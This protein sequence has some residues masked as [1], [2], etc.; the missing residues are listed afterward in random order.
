MQQRLFPGGDASHRRGEHRV[1]AALGQGEQPH[2]GERALTLVLE[3]AG[4]DGT[5]LP[6]W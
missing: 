3:I 1:G 6:L 4:D 2:L 5:V